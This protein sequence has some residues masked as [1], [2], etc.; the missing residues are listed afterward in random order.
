MFAALV[1]GYEFRTNAPFV[2]ALNNQ[3]CF[4][5]RSRAAVWHRVMSRCI[6]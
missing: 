3:R 6:G 5:V 2:L 1:I 4:L